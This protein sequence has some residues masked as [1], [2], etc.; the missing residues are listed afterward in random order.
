MLAAAWRVGSGRRRRV[1]G[2]IVRG[3]TGSHLDGKPRKTAWKLGDGDENGAD[4]TTT[5]GVGLEVID[6]VTG[7]M[8][9]PSPSRAVKTNESVNALPLIVAYSSRPLVMSA[10]VKV[11]PT[12]RFTPASRNAPYCG[13]ASTSNVS[14]TDA[15]SVR[16][17]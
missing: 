6:S 12:A 5:T 1:A 11:D 16:T 15:P 3:R 2:A 7:P 14:A 17:T 8:V 9:A 13:I 4:G 10:Q